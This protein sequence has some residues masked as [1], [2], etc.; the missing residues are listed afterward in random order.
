MTRSNSIMQFDPYAP[1][2]RNAD[3][4]DI[5]SEPLF[6][7]G[8]G[9][10]KAARGGFAIDVEDTEGAYIVTADFPGAAKDDID[11]SLEDDVLT[12]S[13]EKS[14]DKEEKDEKGFV[15][16]ERHS[17]VKASRSIAL[18]GA[19]EGTSKASMDNGVLTITIG[20]VVEEEPVKSKISID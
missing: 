20:K 9:F 13:Y 3:I 1:V 10:P 18:P 15:V 8:L 19:D 5:F 7:I 11:I 6:G 16:K 14:E 4:F 12:I 2:R 17:T